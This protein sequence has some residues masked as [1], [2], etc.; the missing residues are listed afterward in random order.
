MVF[1]H[2]L[3]RLFTGDMS[4]EPGMLL[5]NLLI[6][7]VDLFDEIT[8]LVI[9]PVLLALRG[10]KSHCLKAVAFNLIFQKDHCVK[11]T[12]KSLKTSQTYLAVFR[13]IQV[14]WFPK[15]TGFAI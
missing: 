12:R 6:R 7:P 9:Y 13:L 10:K 3:L 15:Q 8:S 1:V 5:V 11:L 14:Y 2:P 4:R